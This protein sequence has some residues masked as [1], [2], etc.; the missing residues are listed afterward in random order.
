MYVG[1]TKT[2]ESLARAAG[3]AKENS[4]VSTPLGATVIR[5]RGAISCNLRPSSSDITTLSVNPSAS[6]ASVFLV[7]RDWYSR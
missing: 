7:I 4:P 1:P 2:T 6:R 3:P 5:A